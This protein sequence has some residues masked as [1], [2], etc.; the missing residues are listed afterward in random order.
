M[1]PLD[2]PSALPPIVGPYAAISGGA[3]GPRRIAMITHSFYESDG[4]VSRYAEALAGRGDTVDVFA[5]R[6]SDDTP[7]EETIA[8]VR[9]HRLQKRALVSGRSGFAYAWPLLRFFLLSSWRLTR[10]HRRQRYD[11][12]HVHNIPDF[13]VFAA[14]LPRL[15]GAGV[16]LDIHD[17]VPELYGSK[18]AA[19]HHRFMPHVLRWIER[20]SAR[21]ASHVII[22]NHLWL[23]TFADRTGTRAK[24]S[25]FINHVDDTRFHPGL[26]NRHDDRLIVLFPGCLQWHQGLDLAIRAFQTI[27]AELPKAELHIHGDGD[28]RASL[29]ALVSELGLDPKVKFF[30]SVRTTEIARI[31]ANADVGIVPKRADSFGN[32]AYSTK[33]MEFMALGVPVV[34]ARTQIDQ[35]YF[36]DSVVRFFPPGSVPGCADALR[37]LLRD[38][39]LRQS[40]AAHGLAYARRHCWASRKA[41]YLTLVDRLVPAAAAVHAS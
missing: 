36:N 21:F 30:P 15:Q 1:L 3:P 41:D 11:V 19:H 35:H 34:V 14:W 10:A 17:I 23:D 18:F 13:L 20:A 22:S 4:R 24:C 33:I 31:M 39:A 27:A 7:A 38:P 25:V 26:R 16:I 6:R 37:A 9:V 32:Q 28:M 12:V 2:A 29:I 8:G 40:L 5:L